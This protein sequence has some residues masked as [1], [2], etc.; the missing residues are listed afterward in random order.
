MRKKYK[1]LKREVGEVEEEWKSYKDAFI[2]VTEELCG[3]TSGKGRMA[4]SKHQEWWTDEVANAVGEKRE[5]WKKMEVSKNR[6]VPPL[7]F[8][9]RQATTSA[10]QATQTRFC[11]GSPLAQQAQ[12]V[13]TQPTTSDDSPPDT[14]TQMN[15]EP[16]TYQTE[17]TA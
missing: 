9:S 15:S 3:R 16:Y 7:Y 11:Y 13:H 4:R 17:V 14:N 8:T 6:G 1:E 5:L 10:Q 2:G 12:H